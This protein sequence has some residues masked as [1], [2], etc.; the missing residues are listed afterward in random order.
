MI[1]V[2]SVFSQ[3]LH[4][5]PRAEFHRLTRE[6]EAEYGAKGFSCWDQ[7]V[8]M[9]FSQ[10]SHADSLR[11]IEHGLAACE[12]K[13]VHVGMRK[14]PP[15]STLAYANEHRPAE[16][17]ADL[18]YTL[19]ER[20]STVGMQAR[21][22]KFK[23][24]NKL[25]SLDA[26]TISLCLSLFPWAQFRRAK[27]GVKV[28]VLLD[29]DVYLPRFLRIT[30]ARRHEATVA[31]EVPLPAES[32]VAMDRGFTNYTQYEVWTRQRIWFVTRMKENARYEVLEQRRL[33]QHRSIL[34][35][36][37]I[38][39][40]GPQAP[41]DLRLRRIVVW[42]AENQE[43]LVLLTNHM[44][45]GSTTIAAIYKERWKIE[46]FFKELKQTLKV[47]TF[48]GTSPNA[49]AIQIWTALISLLIL[50]WLHYRSS[51]GLSFSNLAGVL[52]LIL[53]TY[54]DLE[55]WL[56]QPRLIPPLV[57][58]PVQLGLFA[59]RMGQPEA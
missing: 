40:T 55:A 13:L 50:R 37:V 20:F 23:F 49:V 7:F 30:E 15:K 2:A 1:K 34:A 57:P 29:H 3:V 54:R 4:E 12:G 16:L 14:A 58:G 18:F 41:P 10:L 53:F 19:L 8:A 17:Y 22:K 59:W 35:D 28:H 9:V 51:A 6:H 52:R 44:T 56:Q 36:E 27:G 38:R 43:E 32:I 5:V 21:P 33:P 39:F 45:F 42:D 46:I 24:K 48:V 47:K 31:P 25:L 11:E 26:T